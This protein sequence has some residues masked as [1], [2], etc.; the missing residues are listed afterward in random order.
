MREELRKKCWNH[1]RSILEAE[2]CFFRV[3]DPDLHGSALFLKARSG[4]RQS[5]QKAFC[6]P[7]TICIISFWILL[8]RAQFFR[9]RSNHTCHQKPTPSCETFPSK[10]SLLTENNLHDLLLDPPP[11]ALSHGG[12][13]LLGEER[14]KTRRTQLGRHN[15]L[16]IPVQVH[17]EVNRC[18]RSWRRCRIF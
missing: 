13:V 16:E 15:A 10:F 8:I 17:A 7:K 6:S 11:G 3:T 18:R 2:N 12:W 1:V 4:S 5:L 9:P 14:G